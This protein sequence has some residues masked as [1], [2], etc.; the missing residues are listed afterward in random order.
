MEMLATHLCLY[1]F[2]LEQDMEQVKSH[3]QLLTR[4]VACEGENKHFV[5]RY[6]AQVVKEHINLL[7]SR[8][9]S[10]KKK[11][12]AISYF[13]WHNCCIKNT[14]HAM[15]LAPSFFAF[16]GEKLQEAAMQIK[17]YRK[18]N[19][20]K[21]DQQAELHM[22][23][24]KD[25]YEVMTMLARHD[26]SKREE[27]RDISHCL[28]EVEACNS[29]LDKEVLSLHELVNAITSD[30]DRWLNLPKETTEKMNIFAKQMGK[31]TVKCQSHESE[32][33]PR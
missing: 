26:E 9:T 12:T 6:T 8:G 10:K 27:L 14:N 25:V 7:H 33:K 24:R 16:R 3:V 2:T 31:L 4:E 22:N 23:L 17:T 29:R 21:I 32:V 1:A 20:K 13:V 18:N 11:T 19:W 5:D 28:E 30:R 15:D